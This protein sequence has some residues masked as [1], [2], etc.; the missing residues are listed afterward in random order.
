MGRYKS[1][2]GYRFPKYVSVAEKEAKAEKKLKQLRKKNPDISPVEIQGQKLARSWWGIA[3]NKNLEG[4]A[5]YSNRI[6]RG[7]SYV[8]HRAVLDLKITPGKIVSLV[9]G[10]AS[11]PYSI[12]INIQKIKSSAWNPLIEKC[13]G[14]ITSLSDL[15]DGNLPTSM[16]TLLTA[17]GSGLFPSPD[18][19]DFHCSCPDWAVMC[20]HVA[21]TLYGVGARLDQDP[22]LFFTLRGIRMDELVTQAARN[23]AQDLLKRAGQKSSGR[24]IR[25]AD[26]STTFGI[27]MEDD[28]PETPASTPQPAG[29]KKA[30]APPSATAVRRPSRKKPSATPGKKSSASQPPAATRQPDTRTPAAGKKPPL[31]TSGKKSDYQVVVAMIQRRRVK[32]IGVKEITTRTGIK[33]TKVRNI[34]FRAK[35]KNQIQNISR[36]LY[37]K[38]ADTPRPTP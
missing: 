27:D 20:K 21:A 14:E 37:I 12:T 33:E 31:P 18:E 30:A 16:E 19:I 32:G 7:R 2:Y 23:E 13:R 26:L 11:K 28:T 10:S 3:W 6:G 15:V 29:R 25:E 24:I 9:Q 1:R 17:R 22:S 35:K 36:G 4:Y 5:D 34:I 8:R 38:A